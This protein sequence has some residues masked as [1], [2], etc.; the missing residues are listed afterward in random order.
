MGPLKK[1]KTSEGGLY[2]IV[3]FSLSLGYLIYLLVFYFDNKFLPKITSKIKNQTNLQSITF[4]KSV[5]G[6]TFSSNGQTLQQ[7]QQSTG[8]Q[9]LIFKA[10]QANLTLQQQTSIDLPIS[11]C[12]DQNFQGYLCLDYSKMSEAQKILSIDPTT[13]QVSQYILTVQPCTGLPSCAS[14]AEIQN[15]IIDYNFQFYMKIR[16]IQFNEQTQQYE[17]GFQID[18]IS[19]D[20]ALAQQY[21]YQLTQSITTVNQG[22]LFQTSSISKFISSFQKST[23]VYTSNNQ[24]KKAGFTGYAQFLFMMQQN[25]EINQIQYPLVTEVLAQFMPVINILFTIGIFTRL[26]SESKIVEHLNAL[27]LKEYYTSTALKL[28]SS[29]GNDIQLKSDYKND[30]M[31][32]NEQNQ[33]IQ[34]GDQIPLENNNLNNQIQKNSNN[35]LTADQIVEIQKQIDEIE[36]RNEEK[37]KFKASFFEFYKQ[38]F[39]GKI[40]KSSEKD[41][42]YQKMCNFTKKTIDIFELYR[43]IMRVNKAIK[44]LMSKE[45]YAALQF[46]GC[47]MD[48]DQIEIDKSSTNFNNNQKLSSQ[49]KDI[50]VKQ[51]VTNHPN[52]QVAVQPD[53]EEA[54]DQQKQN[55]N[56]EK[57]GLTLSS[58][59]IDNGLSKKLEYDS[60]KRK[61]SKYK[62][63][64]Q[65]L[66]KNDNQQID[67]EIQIL[68]SNSN[69]AN[70]HLQQQEEI[71]TNKY[72]QYYYLKKFIDKINKNQDLT[73][74]DLN[75]YS[76]LLGRITPQKQEEQVENIN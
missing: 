34:K 68:Q 67:S 37:S 25:Q 30:K 39:F 23:A 32:L 8:K 64:Q 35:H 22:F 48:L 66:K 74:I 73:Q 52:T 21:Q 26:F 4:D 41:I 24:L 36:F 12:D 5:F 62:E 40:I 56:E 46:C 72:T 70:N 14:P 1:K 57:N 63:Q 27:F 31:N 45:Q 58:D 3:A 29:S 2:T 54:R 33:T 76:S 75:I 9:Y 65:S 50:S 20:D 43:N 10:I 42:L 11:D 69:Q 17:E 61:I 47:E 16:I 60:Q 18:L 28:L 49:T 71:L 6:F 53:I 59:V 55:F 15:L 44:I 13:Q 38:Y 7:L 51:Y 19:F